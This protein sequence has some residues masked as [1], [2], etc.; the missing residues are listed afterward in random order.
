MLPA[1]VF[2]TPN[3]LYCH[4]QMSF[5]ISVY[6][7][8]LLYSL[9]IEHNKSDYIFSLFYTIYKCIYLYVCVC[10]RACVRV[11]VCT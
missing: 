8:H 7:Q 11:C 4:L 2:F 10:V 9:G 3:S 5:I 6:L 1:A